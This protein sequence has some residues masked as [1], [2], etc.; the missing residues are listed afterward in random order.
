MDRADLDR[1]SDQELWALHEAVVE[2]LSN[3][4]LAEKRE[5]E[6]RLAELELRLKTP[7]PSRNPRPKPGRG[8]PTDDA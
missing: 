7:T 4:L 6:K 5:M 8:G 3:R 2:F 1:M